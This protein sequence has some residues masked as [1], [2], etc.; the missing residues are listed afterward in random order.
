MEPLGKKPESL[1]PSSTLFLVFYNSKRA[2]LEPLH[3]VLQEVEVGV[4]AGSSV[5]M[6]WWS[7]VTAVQGAEGWLCLQTLPDHHG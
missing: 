2:H 1:D 5:C 4:N 7:S 3:T 6:D